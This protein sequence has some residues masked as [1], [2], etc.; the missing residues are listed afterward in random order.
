MVAL[1]V[2][3][4]VPVSTTP[5]AA[6]A[7]TIRAAQVAEEAG[8]QRYWIGEHHNT[9][10]LACGATTILMGHIASV[11]STIRVGSGGTMVPLHR[12]LRL[13]EDLGTLATLHP[14]RIEAALSGGAGVD[15]ETMRQLG[16]NT[17][18]MADVRQ[19]RQHLASTAGMFCQV[20]LCI[21]GAG[22]QAATL[23]GQLGLPFAFTSHYA[24]RSLDAAIAAY[25]AGFMPSQQCTQPY[26]LASA[27]VMVCD[28][29]DE[30]EFQMTT[31]LQMFESA[32]TGKRGLLSPPRAI[33]M[34]PLVKAQIGESLQVTFAGTGPDVTLRMQRWA[35]AHSIDEIITVTY[36][37]DPEIR[38]ASIQ[39]L[40]NW[41]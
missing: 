4:L 2:L 8:Y 29:R 3:D 30:A 12:P 17:S 20:P 35:S 7:A 21:M 5:S 37:Y 10:G 6:I 26:V 24:P 23:A 34:H 32:V 1:S 31:L 18:V 19:L 27:N 9:P 22:V 33:E 14:K 16:R 40:G 36:A 41:F 11:T 13:A 38:E 25:H 28:S 39:E 15:S